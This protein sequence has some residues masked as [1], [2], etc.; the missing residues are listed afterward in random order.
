MFEN[1]YAFAPGSLFAFALPSAQAVA[2]K[3]VA[4]SSAAATDYGQ[5]VATTDKD[6]TQLAI[7]AKSRL[8]LRVTEAI[9]SG[10]WEQRL[11]KI[12]KSGWQA[13]VASK[14]V[15]NYGTG[16]AA[17]EQKVAT[18][19]GPLLAFEAG[20]QATV[21]SMPNLTDTDRNNRMLAWANGMRQY[22]A[23]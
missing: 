23:P 5:G 18:A 10:K 21:Q 11:A 6:P 1:R 3:W 12:G 20:L 19:F 8:L 14:G 22:V 7:A 9:N 13:A 15:A 2:S 4:R 16:V 17:A